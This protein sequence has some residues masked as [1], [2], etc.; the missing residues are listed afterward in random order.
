M[1]PRL[2]VG[3]VYE[4]DHL[5]ISQS[6]E[7]GKPVTLNFAKGRFRRQVGPNTNALNAKGKQRTYRPIIK[8]CSLAFFDSQA[9]VK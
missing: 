4:P 5:L 3:L 1:V 8:N 9:L 7:E 2:R 6:L